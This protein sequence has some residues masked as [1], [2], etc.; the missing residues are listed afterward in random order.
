L[1]HLDLNAV[2]EISDYRDR[3]TKKAWHFCQT[4]FFYMVPQDESNISTKPS[5]INTIAISYFRC[6][7]KCTP[8][9]AN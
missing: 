8:K 2:K 5:K 3:K 4:F 6:T 1:S 9:S 7:P